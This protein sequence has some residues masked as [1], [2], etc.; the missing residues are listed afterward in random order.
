MVSFT[1]RTLAVLFLTASTQ[2]SPCPYGEMAEKGQL[3]A[4]DSAKFFAARAEGSAAVERDMHEV[5]K[6]EHAD[7][8]KFYKRQIDLGQLLLG[9]GLLGGVLQPFSGAL[10]KLDSKKSSLLI[11]PNIFDQHEYAWTYI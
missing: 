6:R 9:G 4:A 7:Q 5:Q 10:A 1:L 8:E 2:A 3:S 11:L